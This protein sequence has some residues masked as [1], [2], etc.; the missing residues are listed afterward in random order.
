MIPHIEHLLFS[1]AGPE[2][3]RRSDFDVICK[4]C[5]SE[6]NIQ[7]AGDSDTSSST[8]DDEYPSYLF[9]LESAAARWGLLV[10]CLVFPVREVGRAASVAN[11]R[12]SPLNLAQRPCHVRP[13]M[14]TVQNLYTRLLLSLAYA[15]CILRCY[16]VIDASVAASSPTAAASLIAVLGNVILASAGHFQMCVPCSILTLCRSNQP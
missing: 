11:Q 13:F 6:S 8:I 9:T 3:P 15:S 12:G 10:S 7:V 5:S 14:N 16:V 1:S 2:M 4:M